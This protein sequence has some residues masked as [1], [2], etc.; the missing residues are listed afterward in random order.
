MKQRKY[1]KNVKEKK[2]R[3]IL[4]IN[5]DIEMQKK[6]KSK[7]H[8]LINSMT[9]LE[10]ENLF[11]LYYEP[12]K[13]SFST[14]T[15][16]LEKHIVQKIVDIPNKINYYYSDIIDEKINKLKILKKYQGKIS[17]KNFIVNYDNLLEEQENNK[18]NK[19]EICEKIIPFATKKKSVGEEKIKGS[20]SYPLIAIGQKNIFRIINNEID[21]NKENQNKNNE[22]NEKEENNL[23]SSYNNFSI[24]AD[25]E[26]W[27]NKHK[28]KKKSLDIN[29]KLIYYCYTYLKRK[30]PLISKNSN[31]ITVYGLQIEEEIYKKNKNMN[32]KRIEPKE[33]D[34]IKCKSSKEI[35]SLFKNTN[36]TKI[37][38]EENINNSNREVNALRIYTNSAKIKKKQNINMNNKELTKKKRGK[39]VTNKNRP[40]SKF[41]KNI[42]HNKKTENEDKTKRALV[43]KLKTIKSDKSNK[44]ENQRLSQSIKMKRRRAN[45]I[46][47]KNQN[48]NDN[49]K[50]LYNKKYI[51]L[52]MP[53]PSQNI[54][55]KADTKNSSFDNISSEEYTSLHKKKKIF[56][57][58]HHHKR[59]ETNKELNNSKKI[60]RNKDN[61]KSTKKDK[62]T[63]IKKF[64]N[65]IQHKLK[66]ENQEEIKNKENRIFKKHKGTTKEP[67]RSKVI[68][69]LKYL[70]YEELGNKE[71]NNLNENK[72]NID[73]N[74]N[75]KLRHMN[76]TKSLKCKKKNNYLNYKENINDD[77][78]YLNSNISLKS[79]KSREKKK[80][81][82]SIFRKYNSIIQK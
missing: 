35:K 72:N 7:N 53:T 2:I 16:I 22:N 43:K 71:I 41:I 45:S 29:Y 75:S 28:N 12:I 33:F 13:I 56:N 62:N 19:V 32:V 1:N 23:N 47:Y 25:S 9:P 69:S 70:K 18:E 4:L 76:K 34:K 36:N 68:Y 39:T 42:N 44:N 78:Y 66:V 8:I 10:L 65:I 38:K 3:K 79:N 20:K 24:Q 49:R 17:A 55:S 37:K 14:I 21:N 57:N 52:R 58:I 27:G 30:R 81:D 5:S 64:K 31:N 6:I 77:I 40:N 15:N 50:I 51:N 67:I 60:I 80:H 61:K 46:V 74:I 59:K 26:H 11:K 63:F 73:K 48:N 82:S 54:M